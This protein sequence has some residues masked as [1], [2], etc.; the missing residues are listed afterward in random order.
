ME[1][2]L[3]RDARLLVA[4]ELSSLIMVPPCRA[5]LFFF[6]ETHVHW[7]PDTGPIYHT[8]HHQVKVNSPGRDTVRYLLG[9]VEYPTGEGLYELYPHKRNEEVHQHL[10]H[11][12]ELYPDDFCVGVWDNASSHTPP[13]LWPFLW[14]QSDRWAMV[15][16]PTYRPH[17]NLIE[18]LG[19]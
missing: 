3:T 13:Q 19:G 15:N 12:L 8:P 17:L 4:P 18:R 2:Q 14:E 10:T 1:G 16:L 5:R 9:R 7:C 11:L 6:D